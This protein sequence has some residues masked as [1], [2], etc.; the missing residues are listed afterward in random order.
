[1][2]AVRGTFCGKPYLDCRAA[3]ASGSAMICDS[4]IEEAARLVALSL[5]PKKPRWV[6]GR[7]TE[8]FW[9]QGPPKPVAIAK[10]S[11]AG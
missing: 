8:V 1:M 3:V 11:E 5:R 2:E 6:T 4:C 10:G 9:P 7:I